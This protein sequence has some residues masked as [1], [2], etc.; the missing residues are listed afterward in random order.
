MWLIYAFIH[1]FLLALVN[2][3]DEN[4]ATNTK[5]PE[6]PNLHTR[7][8]SVLLISTLMSFVGATLIYLLSGNIT[9]PSDVLTLALISAIPMVAM[10]ASYFYLL[11]T[12]PVH[13]VA[14]L[15]QMSSIWLLVIELLFGGTISAAGLLGI[16][17]LMYG[18]YIL[19]AGTFK[20]KIP[21]KL[22]TM[23][24]PATST[25]AIALFII[26]LATEN[27]SA[28]AITFWQMIAIG[29]IGVFLLVAVKRYREGFLFRI[30]HQGRRFLLL[31]LA[32]E[33]FAE[34]GYVFSNLAVAVA[35]VAVYV[36]AM[37]GVQSVFVLLLFFFFPI[38]ERIKVTKMHWLAVLLIAMGIFLIEMR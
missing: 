16:F 31:S 1:T 21:T 32:N 13:Q 30:R 33:T 25:W 29:F 6:N 36:S 7:V 22:L 27:H 10:Y 34:A 28:V 5:L 4:L 26:R 3:T 24:I 35:P 9:L 12:Y 15:F 14:P 38:G 19:D 8:G 23:A 17:V 37:S 20:W 11:Q 18:A 2:F